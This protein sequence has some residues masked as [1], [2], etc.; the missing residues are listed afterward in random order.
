MS[1]Q[2]V[3]NEVI[4]GDLHKSQA[5]DPSRIFCKAKVKRRGKKVL[6]TAK[7]WQVNKLALRRIRRRK[8]K[9]S[10]TMCRHGRL[11]VGKKFYVLSSLEVQKRLRKPLKLCQKNEKRENRVE[12][13]IELT[14]TNTTAVSVVKLFVVSS[15][16]FIKMCC[17]M[18]RRTRDVRVEVTSVSWLW[19]NVFAVK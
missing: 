13:G 4:G 7:Y 19:W 9:T 15:L 10:S 6:Q 3:S 14:N 2:I 18:R 8:P 12:R 17:E 11:W 1:T 5:N 16:Q